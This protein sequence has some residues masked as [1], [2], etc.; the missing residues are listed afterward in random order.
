MSAGGWRGR[1]HRCLG[2]SGEVL[3]WPW[4]PVLSLTDFHAHSHLTHTPLP[5]SLPSSITPAD[6]PE[7]K[8]NL[9]DSSAQ[10][11]WELPQRH[12]SSSESS[13]EAISCGR[14]ERR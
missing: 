5:T 2:R 14:E 11:L 7:E 10:K 6:S 8:G 1:N 4:G 9:T 12:D 3:L 13:E